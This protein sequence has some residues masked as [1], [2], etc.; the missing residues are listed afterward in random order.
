MKEY[1]SPSKDQVRIQRLEKKIKKLQNRDESQK[2]KLAFFIKLLNE[3]PALGRYDTVTKR[4]LEYLDKIRELEKQIREKNWAIKGLQDA[5]NT[6]RLLSH[7]ELEEF[8][9]I[10]NK[11]NQ[12]LFK[13]IVLILKS[14]KRYEREI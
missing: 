8:E 5:L 13:K 3:F 14:Y 12:I 2:E 10:S 9:N 4:N 6:G 7:K 11:E 1:P